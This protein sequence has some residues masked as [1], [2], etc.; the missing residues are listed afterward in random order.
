MT[1]GTSRTSLP[2]I[3]TWFQSGCFW[4]NQSPLGSLELIVDIPINPRGTHNIY[5]DDIINLTINIPS[6]DHVACAKGAALLAM[7]ATT[8]QNHPE[9]P[10]PRESMDA[11]DKLRA[12]AGPAESKVILGWDFDFR[13]LII[14]LPKN[15]FVAWTTNVSQ[16]LSNETTT[17]KELESTIGHLGH[18]TLPQSSSQPPTNGNQPLF[19]QNQQDLQERPDPNALFPQDCKTR[20]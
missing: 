6:T 11:R 12:E 17:V 10:M 2:Q 4:T 1:A 5:I 15:K 13:R 20:Y 19:H 7:D 14:S 8:R 16:L 9:E 3:N 18:L